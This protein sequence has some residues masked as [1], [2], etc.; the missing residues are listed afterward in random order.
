M[1]CLRFNLFNV[2]Q[3]LTD[4]LHLLT[5]A[6]TSKLIVLER[7]YVEQKVFGHDCVS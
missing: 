7:S 6:I 2:F 3:C 1:S 4:K 5:Q